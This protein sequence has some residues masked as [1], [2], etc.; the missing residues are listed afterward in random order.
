MQKASTVNARIEPALKIRAENIFGKIGISSAEA[1]RIFYKQVTLHKGLPFEVK[2]PNK[3]TIKAMQDADARQ[4]LKR[5]E[6]LD[7]LFEDLEN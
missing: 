6:S 4:N 3:T 1:I 5:F 2:I 7:D